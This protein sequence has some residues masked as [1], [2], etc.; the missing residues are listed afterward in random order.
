MYFRIMPQIL[1]KAEAPFLISLSTGLHTDDRLPES[2]VKS[3]V[4][5]GLLIRAI[6]Q[7]SFTLTRP[8]QKRPYPWMYLDHGDSAPVLLINS[9]KKLLEACYALGR[10]ELL[11]TI[12]E[13]LVNCL[14]NPPDREKREEGK[15]VAQF[16]L[17]FVGSKLGPNT[18]PPPKLEELFVLAMKLTFIPSKTSHSL[19]Y[20]RSTVRFFLRFSVRLLGNEFFSKR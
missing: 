17:E 4:V 5:T 19:I 10:Q 15:Q 2:E 13:K 8:P 14:A 12:L 7:T 11:G 9:T 3:D 18:L 16:I 1:D 6:S 20:D